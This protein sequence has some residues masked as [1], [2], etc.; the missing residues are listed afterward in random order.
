V[1]FYI[2][3]G[4]NFGPIRLN[5]SRGGLGLSAG[6][7]GARIGIGPRGSYVHFG[8]EGLYYRRSLNNLFPAKA[9]PS[10][11]VP[12]V[13]SPPPADSD[14]MS[15]VDLAKLTP[16]SD[17]ALVEELERVRRRTDLFPIFL[18]LSI[19]SIVIVTTMLR[20]WAISIV[21]VIVGVA[22]SLWARHTD[23]TRGTVILHYD[24]D[25]PTKEKY[26]T[27]RSGFDQLLR[28]GRLCHVD[29]AEP[30]YSRKSQA[31]AGI[32][33]SR[34]DANPQLACPPRVRCNL[35]VLSL[36]ARSNRLYFF[37]DH[38]LIYSGEKIGA[39][40]YSEITSRASAEQ[41]IEAERVPGDAERVG[42]T[43]QHANKD[44]GPDRRFKFNPR[45]P[46]VLYGYFTLASASGLREMFQCSSTAAARAFAS[47]IGAQKVVHQERTLEQ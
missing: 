12:V 18:V 2:R 46:V 23:V 24:L 20:S 27:L 43:W 31:G 19:V 7:K 15:H 40:P 4:I 14:P 39:V 11:T 34:S 30:N 28:C 26:E 25:A 42:A 3:R 44:G 17:Q 35:D 10:P 38:L 8:R 5:L 47:A 41:F 45:I 36:Q 21:F 37:P 29:T 6:V 1:G 22:L 32:L 13:P 16:T 33:V 9:T